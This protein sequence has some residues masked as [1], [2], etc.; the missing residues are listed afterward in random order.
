MPYVCLNISNK[1][2]ATSKYSFTQVVL[3]N[4][5]VWGVRECAMYVV[6][7]YL[8]RVKHNILL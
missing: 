3:G 4:K 7:N 8:Q 2:G 1:Y 5:K 6:R